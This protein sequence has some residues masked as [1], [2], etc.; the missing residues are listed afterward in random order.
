MKLR[1]G[2]DVKEQRKGAAPEEKNWRR[3]V[4]CTL[5][6]THIHTHTHTYTHTHTHTHTHNTHAYT[7]AHTH[8]HTHTHTH[9]HTHTHTHTHVHTHTNTHTYTRM[10]KHTHTHTHTRWNRDLEELQ[11][12]R[13]QLLGDCLLSAAFLSYAGA[14]SWHFRHRM[15]LEDWLGDIVSKK[16]PLSQPFRLETILTNDVEI[17]KWISESLPPDELSIQNGILTTQVMHSVHV[18]VYVCKWRYFCLKKFFFLNTCI[19]LY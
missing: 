18:H 12:T 6:Y 16:I 2:G 7:Y 4:K 8:T 11:K 19:Y 17:S 1:K 10:H 5:I 14:F 9:I 15:I 3:T 13:V